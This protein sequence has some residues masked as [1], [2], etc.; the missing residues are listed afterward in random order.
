MKT[1]RFLPFLLMAATASA[2]VDPSLLALLPGNTS[3]VFGVEVHSLLGSPFGKYVLAQLPSNDDMVR[4]AAATG[5]DYQNDLQELLGATPLPNGTKP[6]LYLLRGNFQV[7]KFLAFAAASGSTITGY[8]AAQI[9]SLPSSENTSLAFLDSSTVAIGS[10]EAVQAAADRYASRT[11]FAG[12]LAAKAQ[13]VSATGDVWLATLTPIYEFMKPSASPMPGL[14]KPVQESSASIQFT[15]SGAVASGELTTSSAQQAQSLLTAAR[16]I[17][18]MA[19][20]LAKATPESAQVA[21]LL[22]AAQFSV[23]GTALEVTIPVPEQTLEQ[24]YS[25]RP[26]A[27]RKAS[28]R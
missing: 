17:A 21:V 8:R 7:R 23:N 1:A 2:A 9:I 3:V 6:S 24:M 25:A 16:L 20:S 5:F 19:A 15:G 22:S 27:T 11:Q 14:L 4:L 13:A 10:S 28:L 18:S 12:P 26:K